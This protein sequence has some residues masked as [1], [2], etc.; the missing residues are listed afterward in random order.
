NRDEVPLDHGVVHLPA[1]EHPRERVAHELADA[2]LALGRHG[3]GGGIAL[4]MSA[5]HRSP[6][7]SIMP[8]HYP[9]THCHSKKNKPGNCGLPSNAACALEIWTHS[10]RCTVSTR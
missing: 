9:N 4:V 7:F 1:R 10:V 2:Q 6:E 3:V 8:G 5:G